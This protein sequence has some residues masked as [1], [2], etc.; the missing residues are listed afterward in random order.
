MTDSDDNIID[1][2]KEKSPFVHNR[3]E[4]KLKELQGAFKKALPM[5]KASTKKSKKNK[6]KT[7]RK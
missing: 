3:K 1:F 4:E 7:G 5:D 2:N 6:K